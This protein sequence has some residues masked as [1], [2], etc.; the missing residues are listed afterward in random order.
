MPRPA[1]PGI[2]PTLA[3]PTLCPVYHGI[4]MFYVLHNPKG[5]PK[6]P[7]PPY[8]S[9]YLPRLSSEVWHGAAGAS[10]NE[11]WR[12]A[13]LGQYLK[14]AFILLVIITSRNVLP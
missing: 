12:L 7:L 2:S 3:A 10:D 14:P 4:T 11:S 5:H 6:S 13:H 1:M 8:G 9:R